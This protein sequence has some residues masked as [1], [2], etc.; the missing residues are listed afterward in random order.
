MP[1]P[2]RNVSRL[3]VP[4]L[5]LFAPLYS[6]AQDE[7]AVLAIV[8]EALERI[9][10]EDNIGLTDL[11]LEDAMFYAARAMSGQLVVRTETRAN[12]RERTHQVD[13]D[14]R[15]FSPEVKVSGPVAM[16]WYPYDF[17]ANDT[18]S[19]CGVDIFTLVK[20][21]DGWRIA[22]FTYS[23]QQ[24]PRCRQHPDGPPGG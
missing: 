15:G 16:V 23:V 3:I 22:S 24:P 6:G 2:F 12:V 9:S 21:A 8:D 4:A 11:M 20:S 7:E 14:E 18:W 13:L 5:F 19:H 17:Y 10:A 1:S